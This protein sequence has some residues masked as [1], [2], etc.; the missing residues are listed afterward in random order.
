MT[1][2]DPASCHLFEKE[3]EKKGIKNVL[4]HSSSFSR[5]AISNR[6]EID[7]TVISPSAKKLMREVT[8]SEGSEERRKR[9][10]ISEITADVGNDPVR[11]GDADYGGDIREQEQDPWNDSQLVHFSRSD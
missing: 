1:T 2:W 7:A 3:E 5:F 6:F 4:E 9:I 10:A 8:A 11:H